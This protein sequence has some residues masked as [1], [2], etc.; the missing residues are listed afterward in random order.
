MFFPQIYFK[1]WLK[2]P[3]YFCY[4]FM[5]CLQFSHW[6]FTT[7]Q[8]W[9]TPEQKQL[10]LLVRRRLPRSVQVLPK[11][12]GFLRIYFAALPLEITH[13]LWLSN[14]PKRHCK[15]RLLL[16]SWF[17]P[18]FCFYCD[19]ISLTSYCHFSSLIKIVKHIENPA[20]C[21]SAE[22]CILAYLHDLYASCSFLRVSLLMLLWS[23]GLSML[24][25]CQTKLQQ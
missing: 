5:S 19:V 25:D 18:A 22:R 7:N 10:M 16:I 24:G 21:T 1:C 8:F 9:S 17:S 20:D 12:W 13:S 3:L 14:V 2:Q 6:T 15:I 4:K 23:F 11:S